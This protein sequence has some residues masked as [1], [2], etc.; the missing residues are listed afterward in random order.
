MVRGQRS[1]IKLSEK[2]SSATKLPVITMAPLDILTNEI[3]NHV[4]NEDSPLTNSLPQ[5]AKEEGTGVDLKVHSIRDPLNAMGEE[6]FRPK[7]EIMRTPRNSISTQLIKSALKP[8]TASKVMSNRSVRFADTELETSKTK[9]TQLMD[10]TL[11]EMIDG[12]EDSMYSE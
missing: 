5:C 8:E 4:A 7:R 6:M 2:L 9:I 10:E 11:P 12:S 1:M 3:V